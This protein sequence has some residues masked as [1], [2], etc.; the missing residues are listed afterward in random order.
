MYND[1]SFANLQADHH[2]DLDKETELASN[3]FAFDVKQIMPN[4]NRSSR[5][6]ESLLS[7]IPQNGSR[8]HESG[9]PKDSRPRSRKKLLRELRYYEMRKAS[10]TIDPNE[11][12]YHGLGKWPS[13][14]YGLVLER[15]DKA[16][17]KE[18]YGQ[19]VLRIHRDDG[20]AL[21][22]VERIQVRMLLRQSACWLSPHHGQINVHDIVV[23]MKENAV[24]RACIFDHGDQPGED[25]HS[26]WELE[27]VLEERGLLEFQGRFGYLIGRGLFFWC[28]VF[29]LLPSTP[30]LALK[31]ALYL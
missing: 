15:I 28:K 23:I 10:G 1:L 12:R 5:V 25:Y 4:L 14:G 26:N 18:N 2:P 22:L 17:L 24:I 13:G 31:N 30:T 9:H 29:L 8:V 21:R 3:V 6:V 20:M 7:W 16:W 11:L 27:S 19:D